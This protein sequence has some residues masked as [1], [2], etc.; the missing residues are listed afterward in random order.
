MLPPRFPEFL[1]P[2]GLQ[3]ANGVFI[4]PEADL[5]RKGQFARQFDGLNYFNVMNNLPDAMNSRGLLKFDKRMSYLANILGDTT[6]SQVRARMTE[7][8]K[9]FSKKMRTSP[10]NLDSLVNLER[11]TDEQLFILGMNLEEGMVNIGFLRP[12]GRST[13]TA[14]VAA[15]APVVAMAATGGLAGGGR[16]AHNRLI[17]ALVL[18][19]VIYM[20]LRPRDDKQAY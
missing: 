18:G 5:M 19:V 12:K 13:A 6:M 11:Y 1:T 16:R 4:Q 8:F 14:A 15:A 10:P 20:I 2:K 3:I 9:E 7:E 17:M